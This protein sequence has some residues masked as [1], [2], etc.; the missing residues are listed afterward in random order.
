MKA[1]GTSHYVCVHGPYWGKAHAML[2]AQQE[3]MVSQTA[4]EQ[5]L[6]G[7]AECMAHG[8]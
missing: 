2:H 8:R 5:A 1:A 7:A 6:L 3:S 4:D